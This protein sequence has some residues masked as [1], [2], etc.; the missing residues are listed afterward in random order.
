MA[1]GAYTLADKVHRNIVET[2]EIVAAGIR[3]C[4]HEK[5]VFAHRDNRRVAHYRPYDREYGTVQIRVRELKRLVLFVV[6]EE[7]RDYH[8]FCR[9]PL[10][11]HSIAHKSP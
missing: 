11:A 6:L 3:K 5:Y 9:A 7:Q 10:R 2:T 1:A 4:G 8:A